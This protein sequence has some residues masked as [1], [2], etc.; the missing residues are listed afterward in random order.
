MVSVSF[1]ILTRGRRIRRSN[2]WGYD[3]ASSGGD[4]VPE[5]FQSWVEE[6]KERM[7]R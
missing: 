7:P 2:V 4:R 6:L 3:D 1:R 5:E